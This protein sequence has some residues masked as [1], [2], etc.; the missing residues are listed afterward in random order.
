MSRFLDKLKQINKKGDKNLIILSVIVAIIMWTFVTT[1]TNPS[2]SR[3]FRNI[4]I[5]IQNQ[6]RLEEK[7]YTI[8]SKDE[9]SNVTVRL[10]G[11][12]DNIVNLDTGDIQARIDVLDAREGIKSVGVRVDAPTGIYV[13]SVDPESINLNI[14]RIIE[15]TMPVNIV[16]DDKLKD[17]RI[18][19]VN[20]KKP[21]E[22]KIRGPESVVNKVDRV[23]AYIDEARYLDGKIHSVP[24][25]VYDKDSEIVEGAELDYEDV[26]LSFLVYETKKV[27]ID[28]NTRGE[29]EDGYV[30]VSRSLSPDT[31][32]I[33]GQS[34]IIKEVDKV[35]TYPVNIGKL[36]NSRSGEVKLNLPEGVK[37]YDGEDMVN[38][39]I[40]VEKKPADLDE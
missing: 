8:M 22:V 11:S 14:Q 27:P 1:S 20:E 13:E 30:E 19:E 35:E 38:Y 12:R 33:K 39:K 5:I 26:N 28:F 10:T 23:E 4:P 25:M 24:L 2:T 16:I 34:Q 36:K 17:S 7:G 31:V 40:E 29:I 21:R 9:I 3:T 18:V 15:K 32:V 37:V 6:D